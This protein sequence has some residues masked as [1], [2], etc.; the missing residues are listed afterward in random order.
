MQKNNLESSW[1]FALKE[2]ETRGRSAPAA[3]PF[4]LGQK[5]CF[6]GARLKF[7]RWSRPSSRLGWND[8]SCCF[9]PIH[10]HMVSLFD[11]Y[12]VTYKHMDVT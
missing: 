10:M 11:K 6:F 9:A 3:W 8:G 1:T 7:D 12:A 5:A 2:L 4:C